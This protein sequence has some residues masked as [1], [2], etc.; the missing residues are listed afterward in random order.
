MKEIALK[1]DDID[2]PTQ[3]RIYIFPVAT[4]LAR[5]PQASIYQPPLS[6]YQPRPPERSLLSL[7]TWCVQSS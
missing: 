4:P 3:A 1:E 6:H 7:V 5:K 2:W